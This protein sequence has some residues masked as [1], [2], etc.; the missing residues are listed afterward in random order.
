[1]FKILEIKIKDSS[2]ASEQPN[3]SKICYQKS[4]SGYWLKQQIAEI[5]IPEM[6][7]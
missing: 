2:D 5:V 7:S 4:V 1:M 3:R 6:T